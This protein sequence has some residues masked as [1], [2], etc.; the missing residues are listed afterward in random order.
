[1]N[2]LNM[3]KWKGATPLLGVPKD[4]ELIRHQKTHLQK[5]S[6][7]LA[8]EQPQFTAVARQPALLIVILLYQLLRQRYSWCSAIYYACTV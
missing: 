7:I 2:E 4:C 8:R 5:L 1:M 6:L 3:T